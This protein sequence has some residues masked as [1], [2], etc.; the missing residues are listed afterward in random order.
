MP[1][2]R[3]SVLRQLNAIGAALTVVLTCAA[4]SAGETLDRVLAAKTLVLAVD[5]E[6]PPFASRNHAGEL[7]GFDIDVARALAGR[8]GVTLK[9]ITPGWNEIMAGDWLG[10]WDI[11]MGGLEAAAAQAA[12]LEAA[13]VYADAPAVL[14][15]QQGGAAIAGPGDLR[16]KRVG[17]EAGSR[18]E[19]YLR[20]KMPD[21]E[22]IPFEIEPM[23]IDDLAKGN[24]AALDAVLLGLLAAQDAIG[25]G[26][27][28]EIA[29]PPLFSQ[30]FVIVT[31]P[32]DPDFDARI[33]AAVEAL[34]ADSTLARL[35]V[36]RLGIDAAPPAP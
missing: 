16:G 6:Y 18:Y 2:A 4:A 19:A 23:A 17:V 24:G 29:G 12:G 32:S 3:P 21:A 13:A 33:A 7:R 34:R 27:A 9:V 8:L 25:I 20:N 14:L 31:E 5:E 1:K 15:V 22:I 35:S 26:K 10:R 36:E 30:P 11:A 28:V